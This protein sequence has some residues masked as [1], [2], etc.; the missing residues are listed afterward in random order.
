MKQQIIIAHWDLH[1]V[2]DK[3]IY[4][5]V[6]LTWFQGIPPQTGLCVKLTM[7]H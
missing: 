7:G 1:A 3:K 5:V 6:V 4:S 2:I